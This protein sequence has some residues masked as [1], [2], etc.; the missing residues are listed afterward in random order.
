[1]SKCQTWQTWHFS[2]TFYAH[3]NFHKTVIKWP[4]LAID[5]IHRRQNFWKAKPKSDEAKVQRPG[6]WH[7]SH[8]VVTSRDIPWH[9]VTWGQVFVSMMESPTE[10]L[11]LFLWVM[12]W[13]VMICHDLSWFLWCFRSFCLYTSYETYEKPTWIP[14]FAADV[15][16]LEVRASLDIFSVEDGPV[17]LKGHPWP[18]SSGHMIWLVVWLPFFMFP[19]IGNNHPNWLIFFRGVQTTNQP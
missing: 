1:M 12:L 15:Q 5:R 11:W 10:F 19:Y 6:R 3:W 17:M 4:Y 16:A 7:P 2:P 8:P 14:H 9:P 13:F 18:N